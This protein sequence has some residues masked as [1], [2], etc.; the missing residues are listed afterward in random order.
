MMFIG[1]NSNLSRGLLTILHT[2]GHGDEITI[3]DRNYPV[4]AHTRRLICPDRLTL[5]NF[6]DAVLR[7]LPIANFDAIHHQIVKICTSYLPK[8]S[9]AWLVSGNFIIFEGVICQTEDKL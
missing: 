2:V 8:K 3:L 9:V 1:I 5:F 7:I 4:L 6:I